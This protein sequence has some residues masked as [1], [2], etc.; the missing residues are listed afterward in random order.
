MSPT[1]SPPDQKNLR[2]SGTDIRFDKCKERVKSRASANR[3]QDDKC[4]KILSV[5]D[6][7]DNVPDLDLNGPKRD[8]DRTLNDSCC[9]GKDT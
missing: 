7:W 8:P 2:K 3:S 4:N 1:T 5:K 9:K 6:P